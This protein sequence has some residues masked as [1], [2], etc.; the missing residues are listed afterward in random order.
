MLN[1]GDS[2]DEDTS[3]VIKIIFIPLPAENKQ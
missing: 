1:E 3:T 2:L